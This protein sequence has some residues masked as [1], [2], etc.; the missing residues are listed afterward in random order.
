M[1]KFLLLLPLIL[2]LG[3]CAA[4]LL[5]G[6]AATGGYFAAQDKGIETAANDLKIKALVKDKLAELDFT[7][8]LS[9]GVFVLQ[10]D[11]V[12][13]GVVHS[14]RE[15]KELVHITEQ[16]EGVH[17]V[18][19]AFQVGVGYSTEQIAT[20]A[21]IATQVRASMFTAKDVFTVNYDV[22]VVNGH[23]YIIGLAETEI[24]FERVL[25][26]ARTTKGVV[27]VHPYIRV[28]EKTK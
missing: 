9:V 3:G 11:V 28:E 23:V 1:K 20:D 15:E 21:W 6:A 13:T 17:R 12:L 10:G 16:V 24:E 27:A 2:P 8:V 5:I 25:H 14:P 26:L 7:H 19:D 18:F 22:E 4:P